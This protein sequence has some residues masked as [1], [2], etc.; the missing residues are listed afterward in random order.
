MQYA[1]RKLNL[2]PRLWRRPVDYRRLERMLNAGW[3]IVSVHPP[4]FLGT[5][6]TVLFRREV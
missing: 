3:E 2:L 5:Q 6:S 1:T 4:R